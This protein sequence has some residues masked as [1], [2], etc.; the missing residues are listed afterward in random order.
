MTPVTATETRTAELQPTG[1]E[2]DHWQ[3]YRILLRT[4]SQGQA[5]CWKVVTWWSESA[6]SPSAAAAAA[7]GGVRSPSSSPSERLQSILAASRARFSDMESGLRQ[8]V[9]DR[10]KG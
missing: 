6:A 5:G 4:L 3:P 1:R 10:H 7:A 9:S 8:A 2:C